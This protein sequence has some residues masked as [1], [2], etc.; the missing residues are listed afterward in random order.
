LNSYS[1]NIYLVFDLLYYIR[2]NTIKKMKEDAEVLETTLRTDIRNQELEITRLGDESRTLKQLLRDSNEK[3][4]EITD[5][6]QK[7]Q[8]DVETLTE[9]CENITTMLNQ[10]LEDVGLS[11]L[12]NH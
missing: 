3:N 2:D 4:T 11:S 5:Q 1:P 8:E 12:T 6:N 9:K 7:L 10:E